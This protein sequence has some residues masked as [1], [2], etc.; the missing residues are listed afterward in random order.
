MIAKV[1]GRI[2][3]AMQGKWNRKKV[4]IN[5]KKLYSSYE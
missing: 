4:A 2:Q 3:H 5:K 1:K